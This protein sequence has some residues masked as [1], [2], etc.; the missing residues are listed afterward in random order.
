[1]AGTQAPPEGTLLIILWE[2]KNFYYPSL[3]PC[4]GLI[5]WRG[6]RKGWRQGNRFQQHACCISTASGVVV[7]VDQK[8]EKGGTGRGQGQE[9]GQEGGR[10]GQAGQ[11]RR[12]RGQGQGGVWFTPEKRRL[13]VFS[14]G[15]P[16]LY[17]YLYLH[18]FPTLYLPCLSLCLYL[19]ACPSPATTFQAGGR[20]EEEGRKE[21]RALSL[22]DILPLSLIHNMCILKKKMT[23]T[24]RTGACNISL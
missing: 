24:G 11:G 13:C 15:M 1:M 21:K 10:T 19:P 3:L 22:C 6:V 16:S 20:K 4:R 17:L 23:M 7:W 9:G 14:K 18:P 8:A 2:G 5:Y 12:G